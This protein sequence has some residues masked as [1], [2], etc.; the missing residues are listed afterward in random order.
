MAPLLALVKKTS[1]VLM[2]LPQ[3][4]YEQVLVE[5]WL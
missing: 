2:Y 3:D 4:G 1:G 5:C